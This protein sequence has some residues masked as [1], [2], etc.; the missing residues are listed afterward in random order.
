VCAVSHT[1]KQL[2]KK[3]TDKTIV[4]TQQQSVSNI[5]AETA[6]L[7]A[8]AAQDQGN[9]EVSSIPF[10]STKG[11]KFTLGD[12]KL[13]TSLSVVILADV[14]DHAF[15][16][17]PYDPDVINPPA[18]F[19]I[20]KHEGEMEP[21]TTSPVMQSD[22]CSTCPMNEFGS[23]PNGKGKACRNG[24]RLLVASMV[25]GVPDTENLAIVNIS[26]T[27]LK[28]YSR[29][30]KG[31][32]TVKKLPLWAVVTR[33]GFDEEAAYPQ[34]VASFESV[35]DGPHIN[36]I[37]PRLAEF[38]DTVAVPYDTSG[39]VADAEPKEA[40]KKSKMS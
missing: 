16:D 2:G 39:Y 24:R 19:A 9:A 15:Y 1:T 37:A 35:L 23:A 25:N 14:F 18:C 11:K 31:L 27:S 10:L 22:T 8:Q 13:G 4:K 20:S 33:L 12:E 29:Y 7:L 28:G 26:P 40:T 36:A 38:D 6:A 30:A 17:K 3:M 32:A 21:S 5:D 34:V